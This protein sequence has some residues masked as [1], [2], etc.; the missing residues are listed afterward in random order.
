MRYAVVVL[1]A[2]SSGDCG[3]VFYKIGRSGS[4]ISTIHRC[5]CGTLTSV[6]QRSYSDTTAANKYLPLGSDARGMLRFK[7]HNIDRQR[8]R[9]ALKEGEA[10]RE[11]TEADMDN[12]AYT[13]LGCV[14]ATGMHNFHAF[15][16]GF[17]SMLKLAC[18][19]ALL[20][21]GIT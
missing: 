4:F 13:H 17:S 9:G 6:H 8:G 20:C 1:E 10:G 12:A 5:T 16:F 19:S 18:M 15:I 14:A 7:D 11:L 21:V 3:V 2:R